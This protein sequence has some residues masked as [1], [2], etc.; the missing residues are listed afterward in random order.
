MRN[1][2]TNNTQISSSQVICWSDD[3]PDEAGTLWLH[4]AQ[5][6]F[7][8]PIVFVCHGGYLDNKWIICPSPPK[9]E[10]PVESIAITL[11]NIY[12]NNPIVLIICN[13]WAK[14]IDVPDVYYA[15]DYIWCIPNAFVSQISKDTFRMDYPGIGDI[16]NFCTTRPTK[17]EPERLELSPTTSPSMTDFK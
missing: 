3:L 13:Y 2:K 10:E 14:D 15:K 9:L 12:P 7:S 8:N 11:H 1:T 5:K 17:V 16:G 4:E 6:R